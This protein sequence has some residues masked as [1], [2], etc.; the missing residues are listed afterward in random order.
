MLIEATMQNDAIGKLMVEN[1]RLTDQV[2]K[3]SEALSEL[4]KSAPAKT[5]RNRSRHRP[6]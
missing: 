6:E 5:F 3:V 2:R 4:T 1:L